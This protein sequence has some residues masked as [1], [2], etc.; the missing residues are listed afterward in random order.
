R[1]RDDAAGGLARAEAAEAGLRFQAEVEKRGLALA[2]LQLDERQAVVDLEET[3]RVRDQTRTAVESGSVARSELER[4]DDQLARQ[5][6]ALEVVR[7]RIAIAQ[8]PPDAKVLAEADAQLL[9]ARTAAED[10]RSAYDRA[11]AMLDQDLQL[12]QAQVERIERRIDQRSAG[13]PTVLE[14]GIRF[15]ER[16]LSLLGP[17]E[18][19]DRAAVEAQLKRLREQHELA[20]GAP[21]NIVKAPVAGLVRVQRNGDRQRQAGDQCWELDPMV[22]I[23]PPENMDVLVRVNEVDISRLR[24]GQKAR[25]VIPALKDREMA[26]EVV[27]VAGVGRDKFSRPEYAGKAGFADVVDFESRIRLDDTAGVPLRQGMAARVW[28][29]MSRTDA[30]R[31]PLAAVSRHE[32]GWRVR[33]PGGGW[34]AVQGSPAGPL[35]FAIASGLAEGDQVEIE[36]TRNR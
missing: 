9:Q 33:R 6:N 16:E 11:I 31:L 20:S 7:T 15:A 13:F 27:Q 23:Y 10:A 35:W 25:I 21:P 3:R 26:G 8:R 28:I 1:P 29:S 34:Q 22:E 17:D 12:K 5:E 32:G 14:S 4:L 30:L 18:A 24:I 2:R 36:R 19:E